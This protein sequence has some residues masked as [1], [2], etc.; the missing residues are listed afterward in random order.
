M[1]QQLVKLFQNCSILYTITYHS[2]RSYLKSSL[3][4]SAGLFRRPA[5]PNAPR[6][7]NI[8]RRT[9]TNSMVGKPRNLARIMVTTSQI[10]ASTIRVK[11]TRISVK[12]KLIQVRILGVNPSAPFGYRLKTLYEPDWYTRSERQQLERRWRL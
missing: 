7:R 4:C 1:Q 5:K 12:H 9:D 3:L 11:Q 2:Y 6:S 8:S 10:D